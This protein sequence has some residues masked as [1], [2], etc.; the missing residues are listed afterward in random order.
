L[1]LDETVAGLNPAETVET[2]RLLRQVHAE[3]K[4]TIL[5]IEH[6]MKAIMENA[7]YIV[8]LH[9]GSVIA[10]GNPMEIANDPNVIE[11]YLGEEY[12]FAE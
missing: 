11:A 12:K 6:V 5:W 1:L 9:Q 4:V 10:Q 8:V 2:M 7:H 3:V